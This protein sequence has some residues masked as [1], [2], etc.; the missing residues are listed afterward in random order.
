MPNCVSDSEKRDVV[1]IKLVDFDGVTYHLSTPNERSELLLSMAVPCYAELLQYGAD[2]VIKRE[3]SSYVAPQTEQGYNCSFVFNLNHI[4]ADNAE[5]AKHI[6]LLK[7]NVF[8][9]PF[10]KAFKEWEGGLEEPGTLMTVHYREE[11]AIY[12]RANEDRVTVIF[13][14]QFKDE[15]DKIFGKVFLQEF[16]DARRLPSIQ[17]APQVLYSNREPPL[18]LRQL[19][20]LKDDESVGYVTF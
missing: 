14:T 16:V 3:Y 11:E 6:S 10:E 4:D 17:N 9:A 5:I 8:A 12:I 15:M 18:E 19:P 7:R 13:S 20:N 2:E 1:D